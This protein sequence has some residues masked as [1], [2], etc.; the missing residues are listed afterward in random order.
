MTP[1]GKALLEPRTDA[2]R[3]VVEA[4]ASDPFIPESQKDALRAAALKT[5]LAIEVEAAART[6]AL[7]ENEGVVTW[8]DE[9]HRAR[10]LPANP[11]AATA[12]D[13]VPIDRPR[14]NSAGQSSGIGAEDDRRPTAKE[15]GH[16]P[17][18]PDPD[19]PAATEEQDDE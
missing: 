12:P 8:G 19:P 6:V 13:R 16:R 5:V 14:H 4:T 3:A 11:P 1:A 7:M 9:G 2:G 18:G 10:F 15:Q 17:E